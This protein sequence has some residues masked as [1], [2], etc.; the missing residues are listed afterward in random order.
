MITPSCRPTLWA[1]TEIYH[2][3]L[4]KLERLP[5]RMV[6]DHRLRLSSMRKGIVALRA[7]RQK[8][9]VART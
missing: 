2:G 5:Q 8:P 1:M 7:R 4:Q 9:A 6:S 3:L